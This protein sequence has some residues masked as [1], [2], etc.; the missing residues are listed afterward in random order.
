[1]Y[2]DIWLLLGPDATRLQRFWRWIAWSPP[3][4]VLRGVRGEGCRKSA[5][6]L[7]QRLVDGLGNLVDVI[8]F[9]NEGRTEAQRV[10]VAGDRAVGS[11]DNHA[12]RIAFT[13]DRADELFID[14]FLG[15]AICH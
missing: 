1:Q 6:N 11:A 15:R 8:R 14:R 7:D 4:P 13:N 10:V 9:R 5:E 3:A 12:L 2:P